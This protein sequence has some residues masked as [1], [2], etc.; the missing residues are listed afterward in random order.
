MKDFPYY[1][2]Y[3]IPYLNHRGKQELPF[4][5]QDRNFYYRMCDALQDLYGHGTHW[6]E[7]DC[8][9][10]IYPLK[11]EGLANETAN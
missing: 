7:Q 3:D 9:V 11:K 8:G 2:C 1:L 10:I 6:I 5:Y 4:F